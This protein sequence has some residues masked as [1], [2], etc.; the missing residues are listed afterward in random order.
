MKPELVDL[1][2]YRLEQAQQSLKDGELLLASQSYKS[3]MNR[4]Y[5]ATFYA[6]R[7]LLAVKELDSSK[8]SG[9]IS[10]F[11]K[12]FVKTE[13]MS[14]KSSATLWDAFSLRIEGDYE[15]YATV[16]QEQVKQLSNQARDFIDEASRLLKK[17]IT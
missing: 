13:M 12:E 7:A 5:Y 1:A 11:N 2:K 8:H 15:D 4:V 9:V 14:K 10:L 16:S 3:A 17:L 6:A